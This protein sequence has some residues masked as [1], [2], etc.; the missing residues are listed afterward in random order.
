MS[1]AKR[2]LGVQRNDDNSLNPGDAGKIGRK[3]MD[4]GEG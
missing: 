2:H 3:K 4:F 1:L